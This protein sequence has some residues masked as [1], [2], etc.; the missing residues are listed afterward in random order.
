MKLEIFPAMSMKNTFFWIVLSSRKIPKLFEQFA[1]YMPVYTVSHSGESNPFISLAIF[2]NTGCRIFRPS[3][4]T[5]F[6]DV[7]EYHSAFIARVV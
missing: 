7:S 2:E 5:I 1:T 3:I 6:A 4:I